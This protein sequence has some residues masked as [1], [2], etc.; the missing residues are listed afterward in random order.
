MGSKFSLTIEGK[1][2]MFTW[3]ADLVQRELN[4]VQQNNNRYKHLLESSLFQHCVFQVFLTLQHKRRR[5]YM[6]VLSI[7][8]PVASLSRD[9]AAIC[10]WSHELYVVLYNNSR[11]AE[12]ILMKFGMEIILLKTRPRWCCLISCTRQYQVTDA[13]TCEVGGWSSAI[14]SP[15]MVLG[16]D[17]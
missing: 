3:W 10:Q 13:R 11:T 9:S 16:D 7:C 12:R 4:F 8:L 5:P 14:T 1:Q 6:H 15:P 17:C 2:V